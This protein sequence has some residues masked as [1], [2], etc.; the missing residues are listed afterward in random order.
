MRNMPI[1]EALVTLS[2][3]Q[4]HH[5]TLLRASTELFVQAAAHDRD[6]IRRY[7]DLAF[8]LV[9]RVSVSE[10]AFVARR[11]AVRI[12]APPSV[13]RLLARDV[14]EVAEPVLRGSPILG[15]LDLLA[16]IAATGPAHHR[17]IAGRP[18]LGPDVERALRLGADPDVALI[19]DRRHGPRESLPVD[20]AVGSRNADH[21]GDSKA[22]DRNR[23]DPWTFLSFDRKARLR[24]M[25]EIASGG[26]A[27]TRA[28]GSVARQAD[29]AF[30]SILGG[31][32]I[33]GFAR[34]RD[35][36]SLISAIADGLD[37][38]EEFVVACVDDAT[39]ELL[40]TL[41]KALTLTS[42][43][44]QQVMLLASPVG[45]DPSGFFS[46]CDLYAG[47]EPTV[48]ETLTLA[49]RQA[50][51]VGAPRHQPTY[52]DTRD[53]ARTETD[54]A[55]AIPRLAPARRADNRT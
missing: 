46:L 41:L 20:P 14:L 2:G 17:L 48:A 34:I 26:H 49:W 29:R 44:A 45:R 30:Q 10:R 8:Y 9:P 47:M 50:P 27:E 36:Q 39:G 16:A 25:A 35:R 21:Q 55:R 7:E 19:L 23:L 12:D 3:Q 13:I 54:A 18:A 31:A 15:S 33:V 38:A 43:Q 4:S 32:Q 53:R 24:V 11:L 52:A 51:V 37:L 28:Q 1:P 22:A 6:E 5:A 42:D 40:A